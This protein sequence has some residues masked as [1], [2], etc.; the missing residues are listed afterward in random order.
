MTIAGSLALAV[1]TLDREATL[2]NGSSHTGS[3]DTS[4]HHGN[5]SLISASTSNSTV[6]ATSDEDVFNPTASGVITADPSNP[7]V[8]DVINLPYQ[9]KDDSGNPITNGALLD[10]SN[11]GD[12]SIG[13]LSDGGQYYA[14][15]VQ[16][17][18]NTMSLQL[19]GSQ[20][21][22]TSGINPLPLTP[23]VATGEEHSLKLDGGVNGVGIGASFG[24]NVVNDTTNSAIDDGSMLTGANNLTLKA[25]TA[26]TI[27]TEAAERLR[28]LGGDHAGRRDHDRQRHDQRNR[29]SDAGA[30]PG[31]VD[32]GRRAR[33]RGDAERG[34]HDTR[35]GRHDRRQPRRRR[36]DRDHRR[37]R[38][39]DRDDL[40][41]RLGRRR[42]HLQGQHRR[43][44]HRDHARQRG[45]R[46][47]RLLELQGRQR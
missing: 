8:L 13:G 12:T 26:D 42:D 16:T 4:G 3:V 20:S 44:Q 19:A 31:D 38:H 18:G 21:D 10:Y 41:Q 11:G 17:H 45:R 46:Q 15:N 43:R 22:A 6:K 35:Q 37:D 39:R 29:R 47:H 40:L 25:N 5:V 14:E 27:D 7:S 36:L 24:I 2:G 30:D 32:A 28:G 23:S 9:I 34:D 1:L 33:R